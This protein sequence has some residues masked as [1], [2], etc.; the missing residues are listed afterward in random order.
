MRGTRWIVGAGQHGY[1]L[2]TYEYEKQKAFASIVRPGFVVY[3]IGAHAGFYSLLAAKRS[4]V[5]GR[6]FAFEP[7]PRNLRCL[8]RHIALNRVT[9]VAVVEAAVSDRTGRSAF[10][11]DPSSFLGHLAE[12]GLLEVRTLAL[13]EWAAR[14][15][16]PDP[17][18][19]KIDVEGGELRVLRGGAQLIERS[20]PAILLATHGP[21]VHEA[22]CRFL[23][24]RGYRVAGVSRGSGCSSSEL[25]AIHGREQHPPDPARMGGVEN[26]LVRLVG[27]R[28]TVLHGDPCVYD[29]YRWLRRHLLRGPKRTLDA[30]CG[31]GAFTLFAALNGN[32]ATGISFDTRN[33]RVAAARAR[34]LGVSG[35]R[36]VHHDLRELD[37]IAGTLGGFDQIICFETIEHVFNDDK[38]MGDLAR[39]LEPGGRLL[40]TVPYKH[41]RPQ[42][43]ESVSGCEDGA[44]VRWGYTHEELGALLRAHGVEVTVQEY[45]SGLVSQQLA[46][47]SRLL[48]RAHAQF[49]WG[50]TFPLRTLQAVDRPLTR[51]TGYPYLS[52]AVVGEKRPEA[53]RALPVSRGGSE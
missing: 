52:I 29:R 11:E 17:D 48:G 39:L 33:N 24:E 28:A 25:M 51:L 38:L 47:L 34:L 53:Q 43:G 42:L 10:A 50:A 20:H 31:S 15:G 49:G 14:A 41:H 18:C 6:V 37:R 23:L 4:G 16:R 8:R 7:L 1:W 13:D 27:W 3:D 46:N 22:C 44:H 2:G 30:G 5:E 12:H 19:I 21:R 26:V 32:H 35:A 40:V 36:F 45:A 9:N